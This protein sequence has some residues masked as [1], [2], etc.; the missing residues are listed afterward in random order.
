MTSKA[1]IPTPFGTVA[2]RR[3]SNTP[4]PFGIMDLFSGIPI[5]SA[6]EGFKVDMK[7]T[8]SGYEISAELPGYNK[9]D[10]NVAIEDDVLTI[11]VESK[12]TEETKD[13]DGLWIHR[14]RTS[15]SMKR[16]FIVPDADEDKTKANL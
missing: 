1:I 12:S 7:E 11:S 9:S 4:S 8:E 2:V 6:F 10:V 13:E 5:A 3:E 16:S 14:E 15:S